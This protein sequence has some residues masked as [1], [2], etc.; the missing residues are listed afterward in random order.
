[1]DKIKALN[2]AR[3]LL[4]ALDERGQGRTQ[5]E[6]VK[7]ALGY[8][9]KLGF[10]ITEDSIRSVLFMTLNEIDELPDK[11]W[12][13]CIIESAAA[14][15]DLSVY[16]PVGLGKYAKANCQRCHGRGRRRKTS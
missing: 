1:M 7:L 6:P 2:I 14:R 8:L 11:E 13:G 5:I 12:C 9:K 10:K 4:M 15:L 16:N 3:C